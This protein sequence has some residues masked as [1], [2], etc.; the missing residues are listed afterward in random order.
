MGKVARRCKYRL[1]PFTPDRQTHYVKDRKRLPT[2]RLSYWGLSLALLLTLPAS[3]VATYFDALLRTLAPAAMAP[4][5]RI[6]Q[7]VLDLSGGTVPIAIWVLGITALCLA[8]GL[9]SNER[10]RLFAQLVFT[11]YWCGLALLF[12]NRLIVFGM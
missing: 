10:A 6:T 9:S 2:M 1:Y 11:F 5:D 3:I 12:V 7:L 4:P 8:E